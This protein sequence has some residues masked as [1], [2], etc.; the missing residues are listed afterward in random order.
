MSFK[1]YLYRPK[2]RTA[3]EIT[4]KAEITYNAETEEYTVKQDYVQ[5]F[6]GANM[7]VSV[8]SNFPRR[9]VKGDFIS[10]DGTGRYTLWS[11]AEFNDRHVID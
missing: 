3:M 10:D 8:T 6:T 11:R 2:N 4:E 1:N 9:P 7:T 5:S